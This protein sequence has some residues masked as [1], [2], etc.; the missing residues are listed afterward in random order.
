MK[1]HSIRLKNLNSLVGEFKI[2]FTDPVFENNGLFAIVGD[3]GAGKTTILDAVCLALYGKTPRLGDVGGD[4]RIMSRGTGECLAEV[5]FSTDKSEVYR[6]LWAQH[7]ARRSPDGNLQDVTHEMVDVRTG[8]IIEANKSRVVVKLVEEKTGLNFDRFL[9][10]MMLPQGDF[11]LFLDSPDRMRSEILEKITGTQIYSR[12]SSAVFSRWTDEKNKLQAFEQQQEQIAVLSPEELS[13]L[14]AALAETE[15]RRKTLETELAALRK[16]NERRRNIA[17]L[18]AEAAELEKRRA[19]LLAD[20]NAFAGEARRLDAARRALEVEPAFQALSQAKTANAKAMEN[21]PRCEA[22]LKDADAKLQ[23]ARL[24]ERD[25]DAAL[26]A[27]RKSTGEERKILAKT[28]ELDIQIAAMKEPLARLEK[29]AKETRSQVEKRQKEIEALEAEEKKA[30]DGTTLEAIREE[31]DALKA[32]HDAALANGALSTILDERNRLA[33][34]LADFREAQRQLEERAALLEKAAGLESRLETLQGEIVTVTA[35]VETTRRERE[36]TAETLGALQEHRATLLRFADYVRAR[37]ELEDGKPCPLC[38]AVEHPFAAG[39]VPRADETETKI[40]AA[41]TRLGEV[42]RTL[43]ES[44][45]R[46]S[47]LRIETKTIGETLEETRRKIS[48]QD[49]PLKD[50]GAK[51]GFEGSFDGER[52]SAEIDAFRAKSDELDATVQKTEELRGRLDTL[53]GRLDEIRDIRSKIETK[54][55]LL[56]SERTAA[57]D[58]ESERAAQAAVFGG[59]A[60][61]RT[62]LFGEGNPDEAEKKLQQKLDAA[63]SALDRARK[64]HVAAEGA[65][66]TA[67]TRLEEATRELHR[68]EELLGQAATAFQAKADGFGFASEDEFLAARLEPGERERLAAAAKKLEAARPELEALCTKNRRDLETLLAE[69]AGAKREDGESIPDRLAS[70]EAENAETLEILGKL[71]E[72]LDEN[73]R[74][75]ETL[76]GFLE[77][78]DRQREVARLWETLHKLIGAKDGA[79]Y[80]SYVQGL[81]FRIL[82][83]HA[84]EQL[85]KMTDRYYLL[86][87]DEVNSLEMQVLDIEQGNTVR[88]TDTLSGGETFLVSLALALGLSAMASQNVRVDSL[89]L[90]EG[91]GTLDEQTLDKALS[92]L[93]ELRQAGKQIG[94]ISHVPA[95][96]ERIGVKIYVDK[97]RAGRST[98][99]ME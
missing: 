63:G 73:D 51:N 78:R 60:G 7:R 66:T 4:N 40:G 81:S 64:E 59:R 56:E 42:D 36:Q 58:R 3:T 72:Q 22:V 28:R 14:R 31:F 90:D 37:E 89:F 18:E 83:E 68:T 12:I 88:S 95:I 77:K 54:K 91:F 92:V 84:N 49:G 71:R 44:E 97:K 65:F 82:I 1:I 69:E 41:Q 30:L 70:M 99:R 53:K 46:L 67:E 17:K 75:T 50:F 24:A 86:A 33:Q 25:A 6:C 47:A 26:E 79:K 76:A 87:G 27:L 35:T 55:A 96:R 15:K 93:E 19:A 74:R 57:A 43:R 8:E 62:E 32:E 21:R 52:L 11:A 23:A 13:A 61:C 98:I 5:V 10:S 38:G 85:R 29:E 34:R 2:D 94:V 39:N 9:R 20:E 48:A 80:R 16:V 45:T